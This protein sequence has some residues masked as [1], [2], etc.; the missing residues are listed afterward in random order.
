MA[1]SIFYLPKFCCGQRVTIDAGE[2]AAA[3]ANAG[4]PS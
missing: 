1:I 4:E 3:A 2:A